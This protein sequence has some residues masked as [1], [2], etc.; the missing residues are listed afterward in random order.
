MTG[1]GT[2]STVVLIKVAAYTYPSQELPTAL[3]I[4]VE[5]AGRLLGLSRSK[6]YEEARKYVETQGREGLPAIAFGR[7]LRCP[8]SLVLS[9]LGLPNEH[10]RR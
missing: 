5:E 2:D 10:A 1:N 9:L 4:S 3:I 6:A 7:S 8:T